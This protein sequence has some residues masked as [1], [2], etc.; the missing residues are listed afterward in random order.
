MGTL[1]GRSTKSLAVMWVHSGF[2]AQG[3]LHYFEISSLI[4]RWLAYRVA[5][6]IAGVE[7]VKKPG[8]RFT[9]TDTFCIFKYRGKLFHIWEPWGDNSRFHIGAEPPGW[10]PELE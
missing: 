7:I 1:A 6:S 8:W 4:T 2:D 9:D 5:A 3:K 10:C